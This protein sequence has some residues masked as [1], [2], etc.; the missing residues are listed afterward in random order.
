M[1][2]ISDEFYNQ[3]PSALSVSDALLK[4]RNACPA[5]RVFT[6]GKSLLSRPITAAAVGNVRQ[7]NSVLFAAGFHGQ[8]W[9]TSFIM[10]RFLDDIARHINSAKGFFGLNVKEALQ[11][12]GLVVVPLVNPDGVEIAVNGVKTAGVYA[13]NAEKMLE[14]YGGKWQA[15]AAGIDINHNFNAGFAKLKKIEREMGIDSP[16]P[17]KYGGERAHSEPETRAIV[18]LCGSFWF[19]RA[20]AFHSQGEEIYYSYGDNT[21]AQSLLLCR[22]FCALCGY[23]PAVANGSAAHGGFKDYFINFYHRPAFTVEI[24]KGENPLPTEDFDSIYSRLREMLLT[25][26]II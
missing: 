1:S 3:P 2:I 13:D 21:P 25:A 8:E 26:V 18:K 14:K 20:F 12:S 11:Q 24:G 9:L 19:K 7:N 16:R 5:V 4:I 23:T 15:N 22:L 17:G 6:A 10:I